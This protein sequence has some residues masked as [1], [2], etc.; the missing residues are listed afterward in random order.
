MDDV[1]AKSIVHSYD[2]KYVDEYF[3]ITNKK[4]DNNFIN[5]VS[6]KVS[7][8]IEHYKYYTFLFQVAIYLGIVA[9][10]LFISQLILYTINRI[11]KIILS[12]NNKR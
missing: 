4:F 3:K 12:R 9:I 10:G 11:K 2:S 6:S 1:Y 5:N 8:Y 7:Y